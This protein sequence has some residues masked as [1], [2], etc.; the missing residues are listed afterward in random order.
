[1]QQA[2]RDIEEH[3][4]P[5]HGMSQQTMPRRLVDHV[6]AHVFAHAHDEVSAPSRAFF[7]GYCLLVH[8]MGIFAESSYTPMLYRPSSLRLCSRLLVQNTCRRESECAISL[9]KAKRVACQIPSLCM[10]VHSTRR[11]PSYRLSCALRPASRGLHSS[12]FD[13]FAKMVYTRPKCLV[14]LFVDESIEEMYMACEFKTRAQAAPQT[15]TVMLLDTL[16]QVCR[17]SFCASAMAVYRALTKHIPWTQLLL[18]RH[19]AFLA[20]I[21]LATARFPACA[22]T[23]FWPQLLPQ[24]ASPAHA[25]GSISPGSSCPHTRLLPPMQAAP[26]PRVLPAPTRGF[27]A[28]ERAL[29][30]PVSSCCS[31]QLRRHAAPH[32]PAPPAPAPHAC[33][34]PACSGTWLLLPRSAHSGIRLVLS[35]LVLPLLAS[36]PITPSALA[37]GCSCSGPLRPGARCLLSLPSAHRHAASPVFASPVLARDSFSPSPRFSCSGSPAPARGSFLHD[38]LSTGFD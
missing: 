26:Y 18:R 10:M 27:S 2:T 22:F 5:R 15:S 31:A 38:P 8:L 21:P 6:G 4:A 19:A 28:P 36:S 30:C 9:E 32:A 23:L 34:G 33:T 7:M 1:M 11:A 20:P 16:A 25:S 35:S 13:S 12:P 17:H 37:C 14:Y 3:M 29:S 24:A